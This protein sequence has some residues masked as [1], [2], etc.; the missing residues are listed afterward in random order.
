MQQKRLFVIIDCIL[1]IVFL[2][3]IVYMFEVK[4]FPAVPAEPVAQPNIQANIQYIVPLKL[5]VSRTE[6]ERELGLG[7]RGSLPADE[8][9]IFV[10][11]TPGLYKFW[12]KDMHFPIDMIWLDQNFKITYIVPRVATSTFPEEFTSDTPSLYVLETSAG[13]AEAN[14]LSVGEPLLFVKNALVSKLFK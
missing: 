8:G 5:T 3:F 7:V 10:F 13:Y 12:M 1:A 2:A 14:H 6:A 11:D 9:M 4:Y